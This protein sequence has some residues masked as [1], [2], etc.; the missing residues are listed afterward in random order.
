MTPT[1]TTA[2]VG[3]GELAVS[4]DPA[5]TLAALGLGSCVAVIAHDGTAGI[6][7]MLHVMLPSSVGDRS[8]NLTRYA[9]TGI[10]E[11]LEEMTTRGANVRRAAIW[12]VGGAAVLR[13]SGQ[14]QQQ[15]RV[16]QRN[17]DAT[18]SVLAKRGLRVRAADL[19]GTKGRTVELDVGTGRVL[20]RT[21][22]EAPREL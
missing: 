19:G 12:L 15:F 4:G 14:N 3:I 13:P 1:G 11:L 21:L 6:G 8:G 10:A 2:A 9:D 5:A 22:G 16:G 17:M 18:Q 20:V 7:G